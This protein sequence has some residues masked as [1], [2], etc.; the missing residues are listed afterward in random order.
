MNFDEKT[1]VLYAEEADLGCNVCGNMDWKKWHW[2]EQDKKIYCYDCASTI[3]K[4][5]RI[6]SMAWSEH[7][8]WVITRVQIIKH[9]PRHVLNKELLTDG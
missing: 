6:K 5:C 1:R 7:N 9:N 2:C 8:D 3:K 4:G